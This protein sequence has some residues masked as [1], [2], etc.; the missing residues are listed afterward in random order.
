MKLKIY[1]TGKA[2]SGTKDLPEQFNELIRPDLIKRAVEAI[3]ANRRQPYGFHPEAGQRQKG[4]LSRRR[5]DYKTSYGHG[6]SRTPRKILSRRG[7]QMFWVGAVAPN[8][9]GGRRAHPPNAEKIWEKKINQKERRKAI[10]SAMAAT[11]VRELVK[12]R[13]HAVPQDYPFIIDNHIEAVKKAKELEVILGRLGFKEDLE[14]SS[15]R[16]IRPGRGRMRGRKYTSR[17]GPLIVVSRPCLALIAGR[18]IPGV[19]V[20][21]VDNLNAEI[22]APGA[23]IARLTL[24]T[25]ASIDRLAKEKMFMNDYHGPKPQPQ[26]EAKQEQKKGAPKK[27]APKAEAKKDTK[28]KPVQK[29]AKK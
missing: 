24:F 14:R 26:P 13:G 3:Q 12:K 18:N 17:K 29:P 15:V 7:S 4:K 19:D 27:A 16:T 1:T 6:I 21:V 28:A 8:T 23:D 2:A 11:L 9:V 10:R 5:R 22:L 25:E 20:A